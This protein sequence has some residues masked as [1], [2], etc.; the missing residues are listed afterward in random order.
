[1]N[2]FKQENI[3]SLIKKIKKKKFN[4]DLFF[5]KEDSSKKILKVLSS[6]TLRNA[7]VQKIFSK[8]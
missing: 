4:K 7:L 6:N 1:M 8:N 3:L 5:G 2:K